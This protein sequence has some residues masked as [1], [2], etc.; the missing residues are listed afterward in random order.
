ML[1]EQAF[2]HRFGILSDSPAAMQQSKP[3]AFAVGARRN[4]RNARRSAR[5]RR[6]Y[7]RITCGHW[8]GPTSSWVRLVL[9]VTPDPSGDRHS[10]SRHLGHAWTTRT[11]LFFEAIDPCCQIG[12]EAG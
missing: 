10:R 11:C 5:W 8:A 9:A 4:P 3:N 6:D 12:C 1:I 7:G 2:K